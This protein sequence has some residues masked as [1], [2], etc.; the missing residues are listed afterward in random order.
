MSY[1]QSLQGP[2]LGEAE[3]SWEEN[4]LGGVNAEDW[5]G[6]KSAC[7]WPLRTKAGLA[8][9]SSLLASVC[10][11]VFIFYLWLCRISVAM[12][13][14]SLATCRL[15]LV[16]VTGGAT[17]LCSGF[18]CCR[19]QALHQAS[20]VSALGFS[21]CGSQALQS[22]GLVIRAL[23]LRCSDFEDQGSHLP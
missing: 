12:C 5:E 1:Q 8:I 7:S 9:I 11:F 3:S 2:G 14:L 21:T 13:R 19:P 6:R 4:G 10:F 20:T 16:V 17:V 15:S 18:F 22:T 23:R